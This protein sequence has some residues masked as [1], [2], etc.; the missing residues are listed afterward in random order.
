MADSGA[1]LIAQRKERW[2]RFYQPSHRGHLLLIRL[3][4]EVPPRPLPHPDRRGERVEWAWQRYQAQLERL[5]WLEDDSLP[6]LDVY[7][8]TEIFAAAF[9]CPVHRPEDQMPFALP[10]IRRA[11]QVSSLRVPSLDEPGLALLLGMADELRARAG[12]RALLKLVDIRSP[13]DIAALIWD[14]SSF[15]AALLEAPEAVR[16]L[17]AKVKELLTAFLDEWFARYGREYL[18][19][20][21][22]YYMEGGITL[23]EDEIGAVGPQ[24]YAE[25]FHPELVELSG[26]YGGIGVHCCAHARHQWAG[27]ASLPELR[28]LNLVQPPPVL[29][30]AYGYL[31]ARAGQMHS[32]CGDGD[33]LTWAESLP[34]GSRVVLQAPAA[35]LR[36]AEALVER[37]RSLP[38]RS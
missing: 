20:Y 29:A 34:A 37:F 35:N 13:M 2:A 32:W 24:V 3:A 7:T 9:G 31:A 33:V 23:S 36:E 28:L 10:L 26:R 6:H 21:P 18:A 1:T 5:A 4:E 11:S 19:H 30:S 8:G 12:P 17:A 38:E 22:D 14:K 16:E 25:L 15:Y 27:L